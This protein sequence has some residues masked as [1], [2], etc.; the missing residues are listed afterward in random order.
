MAGINDVVTP[1]RIPCPIEG[2]VIMCSPEIVPLVN[3]GLKIYY[4][5]K[6]PPEEIAQQLGR[7]F[8]GKISICYNVGTD[9]NSDL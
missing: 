6:V 9:E 5:E 3:A 8:K 7:I 1:K 2:L 4:Q